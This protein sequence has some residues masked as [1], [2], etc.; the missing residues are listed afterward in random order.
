MI[1]QVNFDAKQPRLN[2]SV[3][4]LPE[5]CL[6]FYLRDSSDA[7]DMATNKKET[8]SSSIVLGPHTSR[9]TITPGRSHLMI[10]VGFQPAGLY[11]LLGIPM[12]KLLSNDSV[13]SID[14]L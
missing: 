8:L 11:R 13:D 7:E 5:H 2:F 4:P 3:P 12:N 6:F 14:V 9:H 10:K 1:H